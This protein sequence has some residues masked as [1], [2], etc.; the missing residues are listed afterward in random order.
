LGE[1]PTAEDLTGL[2]AEARADLSSA[3]SLAY[4]STF[5]DELVE[6]GF[7][8]RQERASG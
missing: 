8:Q 4:V 1:F 2:L 6:A 5:L 3:D 7:V